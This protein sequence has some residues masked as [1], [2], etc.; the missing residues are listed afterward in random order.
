M[1]SVTASVLILVS[2]KPFFHSAVLSASG[3]DFSQNNESLILGTEEASLSLQ[4]FKTFDSHCHKTEFFI[5]RSWCILKH[6]Y[7]GS[8]M[9][10][11]QFDQYLIL[12]ISHITEL[13]HLPLA[14]RIQC[15]QHSQNLRCLIYWP[16]YF[17][18]FSLPAVQYP[19]PLHGHRWITRPGLAQ[20]TE[21][22]CSSENTPLPSYSNGLCAGCPFACCDTQ[23]KIGRDVGG[24]REGRC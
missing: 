16:M 21:W 18:H 7:C 14:L 13:P 22:C 23:W 5:Q 1:H 24:R 8:H 19:S 17:F 12:N 4:S 9:S 20:L 11:A 6:L 10:T 3:Q 15:F 2:Y